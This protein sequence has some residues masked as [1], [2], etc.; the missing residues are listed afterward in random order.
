MKQL[1]MFGANLPRAGHSAASRTGDL[2]ATDWLADARKLIKLAR[3][4]RARGDE[5]LARDLGNQALSARTRGN[6]IRSAKRAP[7]ARSFLW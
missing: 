7:G 3:A 1:S 5:R 4:A 6:A 2:F